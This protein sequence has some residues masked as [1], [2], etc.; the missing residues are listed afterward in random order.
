MQTFFDTYL[1]NSTYN[2][3]EIIEAMTPIPVHPKVVKYE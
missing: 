3:K 2:S 1:Y